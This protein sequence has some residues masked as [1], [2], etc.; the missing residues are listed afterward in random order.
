MNQWHQIWKPLLCQL[1]RN[2]YNLLERNRYCVQTITIL[3]KNYYIFKTHVEQLPM[4]WNIS[5][6]NAVCF[7]TFLYLQVCMFFPPMVVD[8]LIKLLVNV[9]CETAITGKVNTEQYMYL[10]CATVTIRICKTGLY[11]LVC[12][13]RVLYF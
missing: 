7:Y 4:Q 1:W 3:W 8:L 9:F 11:L 13:Y 6:V 10:T 2:N 12:Y 5:S